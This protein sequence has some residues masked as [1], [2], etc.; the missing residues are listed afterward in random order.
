VLHGFK[1]ET[2]DAILYV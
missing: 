1:V 2:K